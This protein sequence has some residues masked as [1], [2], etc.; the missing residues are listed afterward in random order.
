MLGREAKAYFDD[1]QAG[2]RTPGASHP[3]APRWR[4]SDRPHR[5]VHVAAQGFGQTIAIFRTRNQAREMK[6]ALLFGRIFTDHCITKF[7]N[8][9]LDEV[10]A[11]MA[12]CWLSN[13][14]CRGADECLQLFG[15]GL[16][17]GIPDSACLC[18]RPLVKIAGGPSRS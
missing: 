15:A 2:A 13:L 18:G 9:Q 17:V 8:D 10:D 1:D 6:T 14:H 5:R 7:M 3:V 11:A 4:T 16:Y 12:R